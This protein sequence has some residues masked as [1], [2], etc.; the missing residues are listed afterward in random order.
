M[1]RL[2]AL[3]GVM[4]ALVSASP[5]AAQT[6]PEGPLIKECNA[7]YAKVCT[8]IAPGPELVGQCFDKYPNIVDK[9]PEK[10][11]ADFQTNVENYNEAKGQ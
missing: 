1:R 9:I 10:C 3:I 5:V 7:A 2:T 4:A 6:N 8:G 11:V